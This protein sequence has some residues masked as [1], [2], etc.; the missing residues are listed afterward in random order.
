MRGGLG[1]FRSHRH[2]ALRI[3]LTRDAPLRLSRE[4]AAARGDLHLGGLRLADLALKTGATEWRV[5]VSTANR[6]P[7][8]KIVLGA[9]DKAG[10]K[11][12]GD[13][14]YPPGYDTATRRVSAA[15]RRSATLEHLR[16]GR[17]RAGGRRVGCAD[18]D[19]RAAV[20]ALA[21]GLPEWDFA[22]QW[23]A[24]FEREARAAA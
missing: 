15:Q 19:R 13:A 24:Q 14:C 4:L 1:K 5:D 2:G 3:G 21:Y 16:H 17:H 22:E 7:Q 10:I 8:A 9:F 11:Q 18:D 23:D 20:A 6:E 12:R